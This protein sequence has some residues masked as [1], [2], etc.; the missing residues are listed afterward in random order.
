M[1]TTKILA[2]LGA[3]AACFGI[4]SLGVAQDNCSGSWVQVGTTHVSLNNDPTSPQ[5]MGVGACDTSGSC[6]YKDRDG[7]EWTDQTANPGGA[8][9]GTWRTVRGTG[10]YQ[11]TT[12]F[13]WWET[14]RREF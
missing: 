8:G 5:H 13:G 2:C 7:D 12:S 1:E 14:N 3:L 6:T 4:A 9:K 11:N 10:K